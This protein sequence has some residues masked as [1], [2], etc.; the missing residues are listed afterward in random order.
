MA[1]F[2]RILRKAAVSRRNWKTSLAALPILGALAL[3]A[4]SSGGSAAPAGT[5]TPAP[6]GVP[7]VHATLPK[8]I[9][10]SGVIKIGYQNNAGLPYGAVGENGQ[11]EGLN[12]DIANKLSEVLGIKVE[13]HGGDFASLI[14]GLQSKRYDLVT[15]IT[16]DTPERREVVDYVDVMYGEPSSLV[17]KK[18]SENAGKTLAT[19]CGLRIAVNVGS[20][21]EK[22][23]Q[24]Q[25]DK[26]VAAGQPAI[27]VQSFPGIPDMLLALTSNRV[28]AVYLS[29]GASRY[30]ASHDNT[31]EL[32]R[33]AGALN[34]LNGLMVIKGNPLGDSVR[35][36]M[37]HLNGTG[38][39]KQMLDKYGLGDLAVTDEVMNN[40]EA[41]YSALLEKA[42]AD[43]PQR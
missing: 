43:R 41:D 7:A 29:M 28:D 14:P 26:C 25:S 42:N 24:E 21:Q 39:W 10:D 6:T 18:G 23:T 40:R 33:S 2:V 37:L 31:V 15:N 4:C 1:N 19:A 32:G 13:L 35:A 11:D 30:L 12:V 36:A 5:P 9:L 3:S 27:E 34:E 22:R 20:T 17:V 16:T 38:E 8:E